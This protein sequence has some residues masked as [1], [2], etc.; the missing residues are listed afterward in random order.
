[1][2]SSDQNAWLPAVYA[3]DKT[4]RETVWL[5][6][7][8][9]G[10]FPN[11]EAYEMEIEL[12]HSSIMSAGRVM[13]QSFIREQVVYMDEQL[14][15]AVVSGRD[16]DGMY[17]RLADVNKAAVQRIAHQTKVAM[18]RFNAETAELIRTGKMSVDK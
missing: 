9:G 4:G 17:F 1:M 5:D 3:V 16:A 13:N 11:K 10:V 18:D 12:R 8:P 2:L 6:I 7:T 15:V 14:H